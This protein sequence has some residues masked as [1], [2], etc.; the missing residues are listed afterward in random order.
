MTAERKKEVINKLFPERR[1]RWAHIEDDERELAP[2]TLQE[3]E[4]ISKK[5]K[6]NKAPGPAKIPAEAIK[7]ALLIMPQTMLN[8]YN[9]LLRLQTFPDKWK[10][11]K[12]SAVVETGKTR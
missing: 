3:L 1:D 8:M 4:V 11:S 12:S 10:K 6:T 9:I 7:I 2:F 5:I